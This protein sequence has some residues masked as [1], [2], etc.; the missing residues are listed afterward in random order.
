MIDGIIGF[1]GYYFDLYE[2]VGGYKD[3]KKVIAECNKFIV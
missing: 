1:F 3:L 2:V